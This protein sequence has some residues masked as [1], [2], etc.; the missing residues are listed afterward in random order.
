M[1][2]GVEGSPRSFW[3]GGYEYV[4]EEDSHLALGSLGM[5]RG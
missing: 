2:Q 5:V 1:I 4:E 3:G